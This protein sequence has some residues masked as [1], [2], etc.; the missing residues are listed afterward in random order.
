MIMTL[1]CY[2]GV[3]YANNSSSPVQS[4]DSKV[5][6]VTDPNSDP[7]LSDPE[8]ENAIDS[9]STLNSNTGSNEEEAEFN[10][11]GETEDKELPSEVDVNNEPD[12]LESS[13]EQSD[14]IIEEPD[15]TIELSNAATYSAK[16]SYTIDDLATYSVPLEYDDRYSISELEDDYSVAYI[17]DQTVTSYQVSKGKKGSRDTSVVETDG[18]SKKSLIATG[19]GTATVL[20]VPDEQ[21]N[22][23]ESTID[24]VNSS[25]DDAVIDTL[26]DT[27][28]VNTLSS[29][30]ALKVK[31]EPA[32]LTLIFVSGQSNAEGW[33]S[34]STGYVPKDSILCEEGVIYS[35]YVPYETARGKRITGLNFSSADA[36]GS[37]AAKFVP[38]S[39]TGNSSISGA[40]LQ[41]PLNALSEDGN[42]KTGP[43]SGIAY[44][45]N[46]L[47]GDKVWVVNAA[48]GGTSISKW[49]PG[50]T[51]Y[52]RAKAI[53][54]LAEQTFRA[55]ISAGHYTEG[56]VLMFWVQGEADKSRTSSSYISY[57]DKMYDGWMSNYSLDGFGIIMVRAATGSHNT[58]EDLN[59][60]GS[61]TALYAIGASKEYPKAFVVSNVNEQWV[62][63][64]G[65]STYFKNEYSNGKLSYS[66]HRNASPSIPTTVAAVHSDIHYSQI[67]HNENGITA[68]EGMY[69]ALN[70]G[71]GSVS[72]S[73]KQ[74]DYDSVNTIW[75]V[76]GETL[77]V[78]PLVSPLYQ[79]DD[80]SYSVSGN[81]V[82]FN[83]KTFALTGKSLGS[84]KV[85]AK[86][87]NGKVISTLNVTVY[88]LAAPELVSVSHVTNGVQIKWNKVSGADTY[89]IYRK[90]PGNIWMQIANIGSSNTS[91]TDT[92]AK[93]GLTYVYTVRAAQNGTRGS[94]DSTGLTIDYIETPVVGSLTNTTD[95]VKVTWDDVAGAEKYRLYRYVSGGTLQVVTTT[96]SNSYT[97]Q[98]VKSGTTYYYRLRCVDSSG[99]TFTSS[100]TTADKK[101]TYLKTPTLSSVYGNNG[102]VTVKWE[103][104]SGASSYRIYRK[105]SGSGWTQ[106]GTSSST[107][108][109][110]SS[111]KTG[112]TYIYTVRAVKNSSLSNYDSA[113][114]KVSYVA[115]PS[116]T[117]LTKETNGITIKW[118]SVS[119]AAKYRI[120]RHT[121]DE[122]LT[123]VATVSG[124]SFTDTSIASGK[125]Y[126]YRIRCVDSTGKQFTSGFYT[127]DKFVYYVKAPVL[128][129]IQR[130]NSGITV[131]WE[132]SSGASQYFVFRKTGN[133][134]WKQIGSAPSSKNSFTDTTV[135]TGTTYSYTVRVAN[136]EG[137]GYTSSYDSKGL[138]I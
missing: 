39:L 109:K 81:A 2:S 136:K 15:S 137:T 125:N 111:A 80:V 98:N 25:N 94:Y 49:I 115:T 122:N 30:I 104:V 97:D 74:E 85:Q 106:I 50:T 26:F 87:S 118:K 29:W 42:G 27:Y 70:K 62:T 60:T 121:G 4:S 99:K 28:D 41:Y 64:S 37:N 92:T 51:Y 117:S 93:S 48:W 22:Q 45:W 55:E 71:S 13:A 9:S 78:V 126:Y 124:T 128:S 73:W 38:G 107:T 1:S 56:N 43:D 35:T 16:D 120:Y 23:V 133:E 59:L 57:F 75:M 10:S 12:S 65:V 66:T 100:Y 130:N 135:K 61:R 103:S 77:N 58:V 32:E 7:A 21:L 46:Q 76:K 24:K 95:G 18:T 53:Y 112:M 138:A 89:G 79:A 105:T 14:A 17:F 123:V 36:T 68:A 33:C 34:A 5:E 19:V 110:D 102:G 72:V 69:N 90:T 6:E 127:N 67:G 132:K 3:A 31:V 44:R 82:S 116:I 131:F 119:G 83:A 84:A 91:Y 20:M 113:G 8:P 88:N 96:A 63:D 129:D 40:T 52:D 114:L 47:T 86:T 108:Y 11:A 54:D 101:I 134:V